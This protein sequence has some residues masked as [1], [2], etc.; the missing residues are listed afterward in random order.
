MEADLAAMEIPLTVVASRTPTRVCTTILE[1]AGGA[2]TE[3]VENAGEIGPEEWTA[4]EEAFVREARG[5]STVLL[6]GSLPAGGPSDFYARL[7][8]RCD[9]R[10][11]LDVRGE[12]LRSALAQRPF[13][14]KPNR[15]ELEKTVGR[16]LRSES[17]LRAGMQEIIEAGASWVAATQGAG[18][19]VA[20]SKEIEY[21]FEPLRVE[22]AVNSI[23]CGD[24][25]AAGIAAGLD[26]GL[27]VAAAVRLG[28]AAAARNL[29]ELLPG[30][31]D[32]SGL[33][34]WAGRIRT[35]TTRR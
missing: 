26:R 10:A 12:E 32:P 11:V 9:A 30:R 29:M 24:C 25:L 16:P 23:G 27:D 20:L 2:S 31:F 28:M 17:D 7:L 18:P 4:F 13:L 6:T 14:V 15:E 22:P 21:V 33:E 8:A 19:V 35:Q 5:A 34:E 3:L 1:D